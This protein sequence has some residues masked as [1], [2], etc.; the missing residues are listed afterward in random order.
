MIL[1]IILVKIIIFIISI[2]ASNFVKTLE[3]LSTTAIANSAL[4]G[5]IVIKWKAT[6]GAPAA[7]I[8]GNDFLTENVQLYVHYSTS[9]KVSQTE[10]NT[11]A[12]QALHKHFN[13][14]LTSDDIDRR[15][16]SIPVE[17]SGGDYVIILCATNLGLDLTSNTNA[18]G[19]ASTGGSTVS[20]QTAQTSAV[21][22]K[23]LAPRPLIVD[24]V[25][26]AE[27]CMIIVQANDGSNGNYDFPCE[28]AFSAP[29]VPSALTAA[30]GR[31]TVLL[32]AGPA[33]K[34][35]L[36]IDPDTNDDDYTQIAN[37]WGNT[38][39][40]GVEYVVEANAMIDQYKMDEYVVEFY[41][42]GTAFNHANNKSEFQ[43]NNL[44]GDLIWDP[45]DG[46]ND[47]AGTADG[48]I[49][50]AAAGG[51]VPAKKLNGSDGLLT[52]PEYESIVRT[53]AN[54]NGGSYYADDGGTKKAYFAYN[55]HD[56]SAGS[57]KNPVPGF[58]ADV[59]RF[60]FN[61]AQSAAAGSW[62]KFGVEWSAMTIGD[63]YSRSKMSN[64]MII[65]GDIQPSEVVGMTA[66]V[67]TEGV[68]AT[69]T[70]N[71]NF[72]GGA[73]ILLNATAPREMKTSAPYSANLY[74]AYV[75][76]L[77]TDTV[78]NVAAIGST[79]EQGLFSAGMPPG[80]LAQ[81]LTSDGWDEDQLPGFRSVQVDFSDVCAVR[82]ALSSADGGRGM[83][84][85]A[86]DSSLL[87]RDLIELAGVWP[88]RTSPWSKIDL[89]AEEFANNLCQVA[90]DA[91]GDAYVPSGA[92]GVAAN[93]A[94]GGYILTS[95]AGRVRVCI[96]Q[97]IDGLLVSA[98]EKTGAAIMNA[99]V[100]A[101]PAAATVT[102]NLHSSTEQ[103]TTDQ[104]VI[105]YLNS[106]LPGYKG[107]SYQSIKGI[108][109][110]MQ[111]DSTKVL[112]V[113][114][115]PAGGNCDLTFVDAA[116]NHGLL[117]S[118]TASGLTASTEYKISL[119]EL[120]TANDNLD[121]EV[122]FTTNGSGE[123][124]IT[125]EPIGLD[126]RA[127]NAQDFTYPHV[128]ISVGTHKLSP[129]GGTHL[130]R[131]HTGGSLITANRV[132]TG[133]SP[134]LR[135]FYAVG[136]TAFT[137]NGSTGLP[138]DRGALVTLKLSASNFEGT[139]GPTTVYGN[140]F[141]LHAGVATTY[142]LAI[143][144]DEYASEDAGLN[145]STPT[146]SAGSRVGYF[147]C[148]NAP[149]ISVLETAVAQSEIG[150]YGYPTTAPG[151]V[152]GVFDFGAT[153][154]IKDAFTNGEG[155]GRRLE[156]GSI[157]YSSSA[158]GMKVTMRTTAANG[159][160]GSYTR[161]SVVDY[162][163]N[164]DVTYDHGTDTYTYTG[165]SEA[166]GYQY[167]YDIALTNDYYGVFSSSGAD[168]TQDPNDDRADHPDN[169]HWQAAA[170]PLLTSTIALTPDSASTAPT[171]GGEEGK[172][173]LNIIK[174]GGA[175]AWV[176]HDI[177]GRGGEDLTHL[178]IKE[179][180][181]NAAGT[182]VATHYQPYD[183]DAV[184][185]LNTR[186]A[187]MNVEYTRGGALGALFNINSNYYA[188]VKNTTQADNALLNYK[189]AGSTYDDYTAIPHANYQ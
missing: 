76:E 23:A 74:V 49:A 97:V 67:G 40:T 151:Y 128:S 189:S 169:M 92:S 18:A 83:S 123:A 130:V 95:E 129:S 110:Y 153:A 68:N 14:E 184:T 181:L 21:T 26:A 99:S 90:V 140:G 161:G 120:K 61:A 155:V 107:Y 177:L 58:L 188:A 43:M 100:E 145:K 131:L 59:R 101:A 102:T 22:P 27:S 134:T 166:D 106:N 104:V 111:E 174:Y 41:P 183:T 182:V 163:A 85:A 66:S 37:Y 38:D 139:P 147:T 146:G 150:G 78:H 88:S 91:N 9:Q 19:A 115:I 164:I 168:T 53:K 133:N 137:S 179:D 2:M 45:T 89:S 136:N 70:R 148:R 31:R 159:S 35:A 105:T 125:N 52:T 118:G 33:W 63:D 50:Y 72:S 73:N 81:N 154:A 116:N 71:S 157:N 114:L 47:L 127:A 109:L 36:N 142:K 141:N 162:Q 175:A 77:D 17:V 112:H 16:V 117:M 94:A 158:P 87:T 167:Y 121:V 48:W 178:I 180:E 34:T 160:P 24:K 60:I 65:A 46:S 25:E 84:V 173:T 165:R 10:Y 11:T 1:I 171:I 132:D 28:F 57:D 156:D 93:H 30:T 143:V 126:A 64:S 51:T 96:V 6:G 124:T 3:I 186:G 185:N 15:T 44:A 55:A 144:T 176:L 170:A 82:E 135:G 4:G 7:E 5:K 29:G 8:V 75:D 54:T 98:R 42:V 113:N 80:T 79:S 12:G 62:G 86:S 122:S 187:T 20:I 149:G 39:G 13:Q 69:A 172:V 108:D 32:A 56:F 119:P 138:S 152:T 103:Q